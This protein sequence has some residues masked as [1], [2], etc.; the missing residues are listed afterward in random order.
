MKRL[1]AILILTLAVSAP[2]QLCVNG[3]VG[4]G[5]S[6]ID[7]EVNLWRQRVVAAGGTFTSSSIGIAT[8]LMRELRSRSYNKKIIYLLPLLGGNLAAARVPL[9]DTL[10]V[11][12]AANSGYVDADFSEST[13]LANP[14]AA[15][16]YLDSG[17]KPS[18]LGSS[19]NGGIGWWENNWGN[20]TNTLP[21]GCYSADSV[22]RFVLDLR[23]TTTFFMWG[24]PSNNAQNAV[25]TANADYYGQR[26]AANSRAL[27]KNGTSVAT[28][29]ASDSAPGSSD[30]TIWI[31]KANDGVARYW[32]GRCACAYLTDGTLTTAEVSDLHSLLQTYL[33]T[34][35]G[36]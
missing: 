30:Q 32:Q 16:K 20:G 17:I 3:L 23:S 1:L 15:A 28:N 34:P 18:Q 31:G 8:T 13:G 29:T 2:A 14:T 11:G 12:I 27:Y 9:R 22:D 26:S 10:G 35:T 36:R 6:N 24:D 21:M 5:A 4:F 25:S 19:N 7:P 33:I